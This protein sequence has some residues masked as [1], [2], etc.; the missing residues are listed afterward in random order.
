MLIG[1]GFYLP[2]GDF[3]FFKKGDDPPP[4]IVPMST[5]AADEYLNP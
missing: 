1:S 5:I 2:T 3:P 4:L